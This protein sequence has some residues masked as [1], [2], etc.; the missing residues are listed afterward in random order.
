MPQ[1]NIAQQQKITIFHFGFGNVLWK[2]NVFHIAD[3]NV[4][5]P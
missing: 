4:F 1:I 3:F 2:E 5:Q